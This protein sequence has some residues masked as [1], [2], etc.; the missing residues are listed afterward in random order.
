MIIIIRNPSL[1]S[2]SLEAQTH[3]GMR[4]TALPPGTRTLTQPA[5]A[6]VSGDSVQLTVTVS[7]MAD[8]LLKP[9]WSVGHYSLTGHA[10]SAESFL[11]A[12]LP[13]DLYTLC[14]SACIPVTHVS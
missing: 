12:E 13:T 1:L 2:F 9:G 3:V 11:S 10:E 6:C 8:G 4:Y 14:L 5:A 7:E